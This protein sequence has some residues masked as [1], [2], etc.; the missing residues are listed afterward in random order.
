MS[1]SQDGIDHERDK[2]A[3]PKITAAEGSGRR[4][5]VFKPSDS[6]SELTAI[7]DAVVAERPTAP[8]FIQRLAARGVTAIPSIQSSG[9][10]NGFS[11][12]WRGNL[13]R[14]SS[15]GR[16]YSGQNL[17]GRGVEYRADRDA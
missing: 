15:L 7:I 12:K 2:S 4:G 8:E 1:R 5:S 14:G 9:R 3:L 13:V 10:L 17:Q 16:A 11:F 6:I